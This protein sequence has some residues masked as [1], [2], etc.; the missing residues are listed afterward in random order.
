[1][2]NNKPAI[3]TAVVCIVLDWL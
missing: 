1:M 3:Y 2:R